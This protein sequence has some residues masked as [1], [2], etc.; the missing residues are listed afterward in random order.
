MGFPC[1][2]NKILL[3]GFYETQLR[4]FKPNINS[5]PNPKPRFRKLGGGVFFFFG[6]DNQDIVKECLKLCGSFIGNED[7]SL[8]F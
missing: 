8:D 5:N 2:D 6:Q 7:K 3:T 4:C 1:L